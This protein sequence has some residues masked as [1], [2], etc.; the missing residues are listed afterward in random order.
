MATTE[1]QLVTYTAK[2][3]YRKLET[4]IPEKEL[5]GHI[6]NFHIH[7]SVSDLYIPTIDLPILLQENMWTDRSWEYIN[8]SQTHEG[9]NWD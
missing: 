4:N 1:K 6:P 8:R 2:K 5:R 9:G 7:A 3:Q